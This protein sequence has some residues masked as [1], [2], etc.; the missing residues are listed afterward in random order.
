MTMSPKGKKFDLTELPLRNRLVIGSLSIVFMAIAIMGAYIYYRARQ[1]NIILTSQLDRSV[2]QEAETTLDTTADQHAS[3][4][5]NFFGVLNTNIL[6]LR[7]TSQSLFSKQASF[8]SGAYWNAESALSRNS[9]DSWDNSNLEPGSVFVPAASDITEKMASELNTMKQLDIVAPSMLETNPDTIAVYF[10]G[11]SGYTLY[12]PNID[13]AAIVPADFDVTGRP[14]YV[15]AAPEQ[16]PDGKAVWS[17]PYLDAALNGIVITNSAPVFDDD[18]NFRGV[19]AQDIQLTRMTDIVTAIRI[20]VNGY[21]FLIDQDQRLI[22]MPESAYRDLGLDPQKVPL[23]NALTDTQFREA[24]SGLAEVISKMTSGG[25]GLT[26]ILINDTE[27]FV[28]YRP[29]QGVNFSLAIVVPV[30]EMLAE[31]IAARQ[32]IERDTNNTLLVSVFVVLG[33]LFLT[34]LITLNFSNNLTAPLKSLTSTAQELERGNLETRAEVTEQNELGTLASTLNSMASK[35]K[36]SIG[37][38]EKQV[39]DRT[40]ELTN[41]GRELETAVSQLQR[42][43]AQFEALAQVAQSITS[44]RDLQELL[45]RVASVISENFGFYHVGVFLVDDLKEYAV[46]TAANSEGGQRMLERKHRL[47]V[48]AEGIV[49]NV[50]ATGEPRIALDVGAD[51]TFFNNPDLPETHSEM[52][53]PLRSGNRVIGALDVQSKETGAFTNEDVQTLS[54]LADQVSLAIENARLFDESRRALAESQMVSRQATRAAW[55]RLPEQQKLVGYRYDVM[56]AAPLQAPVD[57]TEKTVSRN[58]GEQTE[59]GTLVVPIELRGE[60]IGTLVVQSPNG[61]DWNDDQRDLIKAVAERV[62]LSAENA[63]LFEETTHR[64]ERERLVSEITS[65]IRSHNDPQAMIETAVNELREALG[66]TRVQVIPQAVKGSEKKD[67]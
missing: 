9:K 51:A 40:A 59:T 44:I 65:K 33:I 56:G 4:L 54:L 35:L 15:E 63:R 20:G 2:L 3:T 10:G 12:Y 25:S 48:G 46:L 32:Q 67:T 52:A 11:V 37:S 58:G 61:E 43:A 8:G 27:R 66:A 42:R 16:N 64:A 29:I 21:A 18:G 36:E 1:T 38:L 49:G 7:S 45:P 13:L 23:G 30:E 50:T 26:R 24:G 34:S 41:R 17:E 6:S 28:V 57:L 62:A 5:T 60:V 55:R 39:Q 22:A 53:L 31:S 47:R 14:W 19:V